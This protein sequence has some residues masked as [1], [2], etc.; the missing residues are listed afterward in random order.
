VA[1]SSAYDD[2]RAPT[3]CAPSVLD[4]VHITSDQEIFV[5]I[6]TSITENWAKCNRLMARLALE[7]AQER[8]TAVEQDGSKRTRGIHT[9]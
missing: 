8:L 4:E 2:R 7:I 6:M 1:F 3:S 9:R 5:K